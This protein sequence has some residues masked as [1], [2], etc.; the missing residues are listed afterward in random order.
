[1]SWSMVMVISYQLPVMR[2]DEIEIEMFF[3]GIMCD[4]MMR[5]AVLNDD[6]VSS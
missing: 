3:F 4:V 2:Y 5:C 6:S 1:M